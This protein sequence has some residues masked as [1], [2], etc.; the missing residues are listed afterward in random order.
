M[1]LVIVGV[2]LLLQGFGLSLVVVAD[3]V[4]PEARRMVL[5]VWLA[6]LACIVAGMLAGWR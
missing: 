3:G 2:V 5:G 6:G 4:K 1:A